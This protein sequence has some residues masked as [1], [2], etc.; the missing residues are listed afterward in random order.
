M[1][2]DEQLA[3]QFHETYERLAPAFDYKT[4]EAS[5]KP[6]SEVPE[7]NKKLMIA[8][9]NE[10]LQSLEKPVKEMSIEAWRVLHYG[11][12]I[13]DKESNNIKAK[14]NRL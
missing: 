7:D 13:T 4:R 2:K 6:W 9:C 1:E 5:A 10:V 12:L 14:I 3:K 8:V 11:S